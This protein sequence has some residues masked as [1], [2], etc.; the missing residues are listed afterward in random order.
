MTDAPHVIIMCGVSVIVQA[1]DVPRNLFIIKNIRVVW[2]IPKY[3]FV[4]KYYIYISGLPW[5]LIVKYMVK[6]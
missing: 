1:A 5:P 6:M 4:D 2:T 3:L